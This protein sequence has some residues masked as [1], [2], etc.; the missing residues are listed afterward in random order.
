LTFTWRQLRKLILRGPDPGTDPYLQAFARIAEPPVSP[1]GDNY[2]RAHVPWQRTRGGD[3]TAAGFPYAWNNPIGAGIVYG[4]YDP[5]SWDGPPVAQFVQGALFFNYPSPIRIIGE[6]PQPGGPLYDP[7]TIA[8]M[9]AQASMAPSTNPATGA[10]Y[11]G[12]QSF[13]MSF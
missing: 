12:R 4:I 2:S 6:G 13:G 5:L 7:A 10:S 1:A 8:A 3:S 9:M 11:R